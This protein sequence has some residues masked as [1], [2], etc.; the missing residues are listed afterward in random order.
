MVIGPSCG[1]EINGATV[2]MNHALIGDAHA[3]AV[4][5]LLAAFDTVA[6]CGEPRLVVVTGDSGWGRT[7]VLRAF[8]A[9]LAAERQGDATAW[10][11]DALD[12]RRDRW[13]DDRHRIVPT[14]PKLEAELSWLWWGVSCQRAR[15]TSATANPAVAA[16]DDSRAQLVPIVV[17]LLAEVLVDE[18]RRSTL[19]G[20]VK[21]TARL[22]GGRIVARTVDVFDMMAAGRHAEVGVTLLQSASGLDGGRGGRAY[23]FLDAIPTGQAAT[24]IQLLRD[25]RAL[26]DRDAAVQSTARSLSDPWLHPAERA[27]QQ[28]AW[29]DRW[30][31]ALNAPLVLVVDNADLA[32]VETEQFIAG[33]LARSGSSVLVAA[34]ADGRRLQMQAESDPAGRRFGRTT[35]GTAWA[36]K[37]VVTALRPLGRAELGEVIAA[38][39]SAMT[40]SDVDLVTAAADGNCLHALLLAHSATRRGVVRTTDLPDALHRHLLGDWLEL[41]ENAQDALTLAALQGP[42]T[43]PA[44]L[45]DF[46]NELGDEGVP[47]TDRLSVG[48]DRAA[49]AGWIVVLDRD[50]A[51][52]ATHAHYLVAS[53]PERATYPDEVMERAPR[54]LGAVIAR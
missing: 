37:G 51:R 52:F 33:I 23:S 21:L 45:Q 34:T 49:V 38:R 54:T 9:R 20:L 42:E 40:S 27:R 1:H 31:E 11:V 44:L 30:L 50:R 53:A 36:G 28:V 12:E 14:T 29:L 26:I 6:E 48:L 16:L 15:D 5:Q 32:D 4:D 17:R 24:M 43:V 25:A 7:A 2:A 8:Y 35:S 22:F 13:F 47:D 19:V 3:E 18:K 41:D 39:Y 46:K 10:S